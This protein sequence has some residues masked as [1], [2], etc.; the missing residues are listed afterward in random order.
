MTNDTDQLRSVVRR[1]KKYF[2]DVSP[3]GILVYADSMI[4]P[5]RNPQKQLEVVLSQNGQQLELRFEG[6]VT[7]AFTLDG[8]LS[9]ACREAFGAYFRTLE[10]L[11]REDTSLYY[12]A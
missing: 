8:S 3:E 7:R 1:M 2:F 9:G 11:F 6:R 5:L 4:G 10:T 12:A